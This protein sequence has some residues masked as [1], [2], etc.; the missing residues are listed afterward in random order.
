MYLFKIILLILLV[1]I[2]TIVLFITVFALK[3]M[4]Y[5]FILG[6]YQNRIISEFYKIKK[7][8]FDYKSTNKFFKILDYSY[9]YMKYI[10]KI[11]RN[12][13]K[14]INEYMVYEI[15]KSKNK[16][17]IK[18]HLR[19]NPIESIREKFRAKDAIKELEKSCIELLNN[20]NIKFV[21]LIT[22]NRILSDYIIEKILKPDLKKENL[23]IKSEKVN[24][25]KYLAWMICENYIINKSLKFKEEKNLNYLKKI[26]YTVS[27]LIYKDNS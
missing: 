19:S 15:P 11:K 23:I 17:T 16:N 14:K 10:L 9:Y 2:M 7:S 6:L 21:Q 22:H 24:N 4:L 5:L 18:I 27:L 8:N 1:L 20:H 3:V 13:Y 26:D 25:S 12:S